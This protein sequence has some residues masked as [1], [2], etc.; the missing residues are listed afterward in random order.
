MRDLSPL[1]EGLICGL[2][3]GRVLRYLLTENAKTVVEL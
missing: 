1:S 2:P 3:R